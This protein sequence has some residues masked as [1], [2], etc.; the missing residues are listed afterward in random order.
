[1]LHKLT[2]ELV[3]RGVP[4]LYAQ[5]EIEDP[6]VYAR[7]ELFAF[8]WQ[9]F[10]LEAEIQKADVLF[11]GFVAGFERELGYFSLGELKEATRPI[12]IEWFDEP[13]RLSKIKRE[14]NS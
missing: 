13:V 14:L 3:K 8:D 5:E 9:W 6:L 4:P 7:I 1:M 10:V 11:F 12:I 2:V